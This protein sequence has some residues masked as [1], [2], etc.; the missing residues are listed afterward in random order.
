[1]AQ[2]YSLI[3]TD[4]T[5]TAQ[6]CMLGVFNG[7]G[8]GRVLRI[9]RVTALNNQITAVAGQVTNLELRRLTAGSSGTTVTPFKHDTNNESFPG[10][11]V[12]SHNMT[13]TS[14]TTLHRVFWS[15]NEPVA[16]LISIDA[17]ETIPELCDMWNAVSDPN[18]EPL[19]CPEGYGIGLFNT[20]ATSGT[21]D[22]HFEVT[23]ANT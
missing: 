8:S 15:T 3:A 11:I 17:F 21:C 5:F 4:V 1:M 12:V 18:T 9:Y 14:T 19:V 6:K 7:S 13:T 10:Q 2:T 20:G 23:L 22:I 16:D